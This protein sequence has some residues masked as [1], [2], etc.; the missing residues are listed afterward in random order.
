MQGYGTLDEATHVLA[1]YNLAC[2]LARLGQVEK[3]LALLGEIR[4]AKCPKCADILE[5]AASDEDLAP[6][7]TRADLRALVE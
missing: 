6:L 5:R 3:A 1:R 7:R 2:A 4:H